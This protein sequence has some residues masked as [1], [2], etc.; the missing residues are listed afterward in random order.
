M[1]EAFCIMNNCRRRAPADEAFCSVHRRPEGPTLLERTRAYLVDA[2]EAHE[3]SDGRGLLNEVDAH[4]A[5]RESDRC[6]FC[7]ST[8]MF[9]ERADFSSC[10]VTCNDCGARGPTSCDENDA[11]AEASGNGDC[12]PG[13]LAAKRLWS[14]RARTALTEDKG[15]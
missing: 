10:Y 7:A 8:D 12:E 14:L 3:H 15:K 6:P 2:L 9:V 13:E 4:L 1:A 5:D 11:D